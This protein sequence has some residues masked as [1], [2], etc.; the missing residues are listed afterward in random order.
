MMGI[1]DEAEGTRECKCENEEPD[2]V[3]GTCC[4]RRPTDMLERMLACFRRGKQTTNTKFRKLVYSDREDSD[5]GASEMLV[6]NMSGL[7]LEALPFAVVVV[8]DCV[9]VMSKEWYAHVLIMPTPAS[10]LGEFH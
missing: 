9:S 4:S 6:C 8:S 2:H 5:V 3:E 7:I 10:A 1:C